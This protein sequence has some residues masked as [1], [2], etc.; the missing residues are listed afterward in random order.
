MERRSQLRGFTKFGSD[1]AKFKKSRIGKVSLTWT[2]KK[3]DFT[4]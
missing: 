3:K 1:D 4:N 2:R